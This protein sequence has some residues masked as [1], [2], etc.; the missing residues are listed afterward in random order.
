[1]LK[2]TI[3]YK[4]GCPKCRLT[5][6][7]L[8]PL[9]KLNLIKLDVNKP[10]LILYQLKKQGFQSFPVVKVHQDNKLIDQWCDFRVDKIKQ[11]KEMKNKK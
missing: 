9:F 1:M 5:I 8:K 6:N 10:N 2:V 7:Q 3:Y 4:D 11:L